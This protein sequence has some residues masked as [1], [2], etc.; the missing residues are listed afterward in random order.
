MMTV[1]DQIEALV[2][3]R[4][5]LTE[6]AIADQLFENGYQQRVNP[7]CRRLVREKRLRREGKGGAGDPFR[8]YSRE[9]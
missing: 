5:G 4:S 2:Q 1:I 7:S 6:A 8:Y 3:S 9:E